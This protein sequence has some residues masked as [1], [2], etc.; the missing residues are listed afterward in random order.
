MSSLLCKSFIIC[1]PLAQDYS[2]HCCYCWCELVN[3]NAVY[4]YAH[5]T[6]TLVLPSAAASVVAAANPAVTTSKDMGSPWPNCLKVFFTVLVNG[7]YR[8]ISN[9]SCKI[10]ILAVRID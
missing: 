3:I 6:T 7:E 4:V 1:V 2:A 9:G 10:S 5:F 8:R